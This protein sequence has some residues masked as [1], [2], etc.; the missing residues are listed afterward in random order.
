MQPTK[1]EL[2]TQLNFMTQIKLLELQ[3]FLQLLDSCSNSNAAYQA[4]IRH[5]AQI[6]SQVQILEF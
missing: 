1:L 5:T 2:C 6:L 4:E 3:I